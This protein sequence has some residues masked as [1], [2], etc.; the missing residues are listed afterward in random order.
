MRVLYTGFKGK[1]QFILQVAIQDFRRKAVFV[2]IPSTRNMSEGLMGKIV[3]CM[4]MFID[5]YRI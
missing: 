2:H 3:K 4:E 5:V 1:K